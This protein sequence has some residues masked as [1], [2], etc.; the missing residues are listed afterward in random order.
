MKVL[1]VE[2]DPIVQRGLCRTLRS[3]GATVLTAATADGAISQLNECPDLIILDVY[4]DNG[5]NGICVAEQACAMRPSPMVVAISGQAGA[6]EAFRLAQ[7]GVCAY[8][9]KPLDLESFVA[10]IESLLQ[11]PPEFVPHLLAH[12]GRSSYNTVLERVRQTMLEQALAKTDGN[13]SHAA[14]MLA[15][16]RQAVQQMISNFELNARDHK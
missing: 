16:S 8:I 7:A 12:V 9:P 13:R 1:V 15:V 5:G 2:N 4:L 14:K 10:V 3:W 11:K 6:A